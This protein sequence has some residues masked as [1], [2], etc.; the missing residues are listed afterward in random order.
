M[1]F[2]Y[3]KWPLYQRAQ[4]QQKIQTQLRQRHRTL[5]GKLDQGKHQ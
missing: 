2:S 1:D 3:R 5:P 4:D